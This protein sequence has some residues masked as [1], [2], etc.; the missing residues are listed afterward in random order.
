EYYIRGKHFTYEGDHANLQ[1]M[2]RSTE[3][4]VIRQ[5]LYMQGFPFKFN[6]IPGMQNSVADWQSR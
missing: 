5:R 4:K 6:H 3:A 1:W 2:E